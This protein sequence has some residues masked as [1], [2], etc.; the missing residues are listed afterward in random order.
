RVRFSVLF[1]LTAAAVLAYLCRSAIGVA[2]STIRGEFQLSE[3]QSGWF[4]GA[5]FWTY[6]V[7]Q[8]PGGWLAHRRGTRVAMALFVLM[9]SASTLALGLAP[10][11]WLLIAAQFFMGIAQAGLF[12]A[13]C[14]SISHWIPLARRTFACGIL[15]TGMQ[16]GAIAAALLTGILIGQIGWRWVFVCFALPG[17]IWV[18]RFWWRFRDDPRADPS[19]NAA[20][21]ALIESDRDEPVP[22]STEEA[23]EPTPWLAMARN[24]AV[25][26]L[27]G[28][29]VCRAAGY[30]FFA[31]WF[32]TFLQETR[33]ISVKDSGYLQALVFSGTLTGCLLGGWLTDLIWTRTRSLRLSRSGVGAAFLGACGLLILGAWFVQSI[34]LGVALLTLGSLFAA[35]A[36][37]CAFSA[38]I[39]I[40]GRHT[41]QVFGV[42]N[43]T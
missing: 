14:L 30:M 33:G 34:P 32:P 2:E 40:G 7:F 42:M 16:V 1:W 6:A 15:T 12:P 23:G 38:C 13:S 20:E 9:G 24:P 4:M 22:S 35:L 43:M 39:D 31:S 3:S 37:P 27:C 25:W 17:F 10:A 18:L 36:G 11:F 29:Q 8:V 28:Q 21:L 41:P 5:F 19:V 26:F